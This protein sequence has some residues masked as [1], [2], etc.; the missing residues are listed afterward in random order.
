MKIL[1]IRFSSIGDIVLTSAVVRCIKQQR[2]DC[3]LH[4]VTKSSFAFL[5]ENNPSIQKVYSIKKGIREVL[6]A[7]KKENYDLVI[8]LHVNLRSRLLINALGV[9]SIGYD[10]K[11]FKRWMLVNVKGYHKANRHVVERYFDAVKSLGIVNDHKGLDYFFAKDF[12]MPRELSTLIPE[13]FVALVIGGT[14]FTKRLPLDK[15]IELVNQLQ[16]PCVILG[17]KEEE[18]TGRE[19]EHS[20]KGKAINLCNRSSLDESSWVVKQSLFVV[21]HDTGLMHIAA[22]FS[23]KIYSVW[24]GTTP[25]LGMYP[26]L[27]ENAPEFETLEVKDLSCRPC[28][29]IGKS[30]C[31]KQHFRCMRDIDFSE[32]SKA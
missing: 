23:K 29:K 10:K 16:Y 2:P 15:L 20:V 22:A 28:S 27:P 5:V 18:M 19:L 1:I 4:F 12:S 14:H 21:T 30:T 9:K 17:G 8:D 31:P 25:S 6:P 3:D 32:L 13:N 7:M 24:G 11:I 26:Y